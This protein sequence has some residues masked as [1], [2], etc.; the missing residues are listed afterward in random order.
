VV[1]QD[2]VRWGGDRDRLIEIESQGTNARPVQVA[3]RAVDYHAGDIDD[4]GKLG[5]ELVLALDEI[6][7]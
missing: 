7:L 1:P 4:I 5:D 6:P 3:G 2:Q